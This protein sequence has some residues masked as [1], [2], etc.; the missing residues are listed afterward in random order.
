MLEFRRRCPLLK[1]S[2]IEHLLVGVRSLRPHK[3]SRDNNERLLFRRIQRFLRWL[4][5]Q[6]NDKFCFFEVDSAQQI[7]DH[8]VTG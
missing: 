8:N 3:G 2:V 5:Q 1:V 4:A 6:F 7:H